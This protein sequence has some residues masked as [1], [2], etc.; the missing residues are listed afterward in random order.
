M[1][2]LAD[3]KVG[4]EGYIEQVQCK[5]SPAGNIFGYG[6]DPGTEVT[7][8]KQPLWRPLGTAGAGV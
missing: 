3:L 8:L 4:M 2:T 1:T 5:E 7:L 6:A